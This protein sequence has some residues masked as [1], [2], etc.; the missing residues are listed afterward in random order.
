MDLI[1]ASKG[2]FHKSPPIQGRHISLVV[3]AFYGLP[4]VSHG[5]KPQMGWIS[6]L[7]EKEQEQA[8]EAG[9]AQFQSL[10]SASLRPAL[11]QLAAWLHWTHVGIT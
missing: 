2:D 3:I 1:F 11:E 5:I 8:R 6:E 10:T 7:G 9:G 4:K